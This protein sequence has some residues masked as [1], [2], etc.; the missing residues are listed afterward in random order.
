MK[1]EKNK[2]SDLPAAGLL[3]EGTNVDQTLFKLQ[4]TL[5]CL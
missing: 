5:A 4:Y 2:K 1:G 3:G